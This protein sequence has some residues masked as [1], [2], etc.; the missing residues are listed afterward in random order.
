MVAVR[1]AIASAMTFVKDV[2]GSEVERATVEEVEFFQSQSYWSVTLGLLPKLDPIEAA[3]TS[4]REV[5]YRI[6]IV[7]AESG[8]VTAMR[9]RE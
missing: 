9:F 8:E 2:L 4:K 6:F 7:D 5:R 3:L 1:Q